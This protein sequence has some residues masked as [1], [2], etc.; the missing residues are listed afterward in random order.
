MSREIGVD[1]GN[2]EEREEKAKGILCN[3]REALH[4]LPATGFAH[5][6]K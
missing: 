5:F 1:V 6:I 3:V 2:K 4:N